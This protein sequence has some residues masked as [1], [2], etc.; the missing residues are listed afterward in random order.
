[1][2]RLLTSL[3]S[4]HRRAFLCGLQ[5]RGSELPQNYLITPGL[6]FSDKLFH[7]TNQFT[8]LA[9]M[10]PQISRRFTGHQFLFYWH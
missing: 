9:V 4:T 6:F 10:N 8:D 5:T 3:S 2:E 7:V 1:M